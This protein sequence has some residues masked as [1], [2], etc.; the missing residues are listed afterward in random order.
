MLTEK[1]WVS[2]EGSSVANGG[3]C[4]VGER[5]TSMEED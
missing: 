3:G 4:D 1:M 2:L 5:K